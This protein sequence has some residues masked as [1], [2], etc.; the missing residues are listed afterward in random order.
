MEKRRANNVA[1]KKTS[2]YVKELHAKIVRACMRIREG[3]R[4][5][6]LPMHSTTMLFS[7]MKS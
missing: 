6:Y 2:T 3:D 5:R 1:F 4:S 7:R